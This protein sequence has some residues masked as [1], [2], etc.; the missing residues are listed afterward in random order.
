MAAIDGMFA[1]FC[2]AFIKSEIHGKAQIVTASTVNNNN[3]RQ[4]NIG[5]Y[6]SI[7]Q[8]HRAHQFHHN[9][10]ED[11]LHID[12]ETKVICAHTHTHSED[13]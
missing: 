13:I 9:D 4:A 10:F 5:N 11:N 2:F 7:S 6:A 3:K 8:R 1:S 12:R